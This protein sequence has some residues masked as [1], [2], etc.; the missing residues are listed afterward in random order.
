A[1][2]D[3]LALPA[4]DDPALATRVERAAGSDDVPAALARRGVQPPLSTT[5]GATTL[6]TLVRALPDGSRLVLLFNEGRDAA[7]WTV[8]LASPAARAELLDPESGVASAVELRD[9]T[10]LDVT[11]PAARAR[12]LLLR[13]S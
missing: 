4:Y 1:M 13:A 5:G 8:R 11:L 2:T 10:E 12:V 3:P 7:T 6:S 9:A